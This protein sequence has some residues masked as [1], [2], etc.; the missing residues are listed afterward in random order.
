MNPDLEIAKR[1]IQKAYSI[2]RRWVRARP[3]ANYSDVYGLFFDWDK[4]VISFTERISPSG[5]NPSHAISLS[6]MDDDTEVEANSF[7]QYQ[8]EQEIS[9]AKW[10]RIQELKGSEAVRE[11]ERL[12]HRVEM[13]PQYPYL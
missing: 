4:D 8:A 11:L 7:A 1:T 3:Y 13:A 5:F 10:K 9:T 2:A 12:G 6:Y